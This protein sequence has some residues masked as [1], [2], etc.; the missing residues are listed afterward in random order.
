M[1]IEELQKAIRQ[2][3]RQPGAAITLIAV[4]ALTAG[5]TAAAVDVMAS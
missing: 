1:S 3:A 4:L 2:L 5:V